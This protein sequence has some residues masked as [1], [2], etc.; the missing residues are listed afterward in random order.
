[1]N[2]A[3]Y[4]TP[5]KVMEPWTL[6]NLGDVATQAVDNADRQEGAIKFTFTGHGTVRVIG[7]AVDL[8]T[9]AGKSLRI[10]YRVDSPPKERVSIALG[11][12]GAPV[13][14]TS[15][16]AASPVGTWTSISIPLSCFET[17]GADLRSVTTPFMLENH[18][19]FVVSLTGIRLDAEGGDA[20]CPSIVATK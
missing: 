5:G 19:A 11:G 9:E 20:K 7:P 3:T 6:K 10:D 18:G 13:D 8:S 1:M 17:A 4:Y 2:I 12:N 14:V 16:F 15:L